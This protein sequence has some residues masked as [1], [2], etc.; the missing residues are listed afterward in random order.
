ML[1]SIEDYEWKEVEDTAYEKTLVNMDRDLLY[2]EDTWQNQTTFS[3]IEEAEDRYKIRLSHNYNAP[4]HPDTTL[5]TAMEW[6]DADAF[7]EAKRR[8]LVD[9]S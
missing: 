3:D 7:L 4:D 6:E 1:D 9:G 8:G 5:H 2:I